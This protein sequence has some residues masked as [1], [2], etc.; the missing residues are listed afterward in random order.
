MV[1]GIQALV[2]QATESR[3]GNPNYVYYALARQQRFYEY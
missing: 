1:E 3:Q 2:D